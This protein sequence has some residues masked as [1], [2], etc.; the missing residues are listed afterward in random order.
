MKQLVLQDIFL[1]YL[2]REHE[3]TSIATADKMNYIGY[4]RGFDNQIV[5][6][7]LEQGQ[8]MLFKNNIISI[9]SE[10]QI[11]SEKYKENYD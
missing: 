2:R 5:I 8:V 3:K 1:N 4:I 10:I 7:D 9:T 11:L 6:L